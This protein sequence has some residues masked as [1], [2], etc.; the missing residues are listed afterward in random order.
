M[1]MREVYKKYT[2]SELIVMA[3][4]SGEISHNMHLDSKSHA[5]PND[6]LNGAATPIN[7]QSGGDSRY[8]YD[9]SDVVLEEIGNKLGDDIVRNCEN[10]DGELD[11]RRLTGQQALKFMNVTGLDLGRH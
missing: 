5:L 11:L 8:D 7:K 1:P 6:A 3:W 2:K 4:R 9:P 10:A